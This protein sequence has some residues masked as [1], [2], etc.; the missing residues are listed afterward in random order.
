MRDEG[1]YAPADAEHLA[2]VRA[3]AIVDCEL[4]DDD[5]RRGVL[6]CDHRD[7]YRETE[8]G[9]R[10]LADEMQKIRERKAKA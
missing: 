6:I 2:Y 1:T 7:H 10:L 3:Q 8:H 5:G 4:C 9:R